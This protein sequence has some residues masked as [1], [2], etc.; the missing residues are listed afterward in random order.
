MTRHWGGLETQRLMADIRSSLLEIVRTA[1]TVGAPSAAS[2][3]IVLRDVDIDGARDICRALLSH[4]HRM[5]TRTGTADCRCPDL[6]RP[7]AQDAR[8]QCIVDLAGGE[9]RTAASPVQRCEGAHSC[10]DRR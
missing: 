1:D 8:R 6:C 3:L 5:H 7:R 2:I 9:Q 4:L 10:G